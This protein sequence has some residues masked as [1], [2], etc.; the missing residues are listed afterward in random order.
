MF[1]LLVTTAYEEPEDQDE[2]CVDEVAQQTLS[3]TC[4]YTSIMNIINS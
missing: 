1:I 3:K 4:W 2:E